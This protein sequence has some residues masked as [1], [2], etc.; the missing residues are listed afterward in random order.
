MLKILKIFFTTLTILTM[1]VLYFGCSGQNTKG[2]TDMVINESAK[3]N[4]ISA[5]VAKFGDSAR[6]RIDKGVNQVSLRW[7]KSDGTAQDFQ[8]FCLN[9][10]S[11]DSV[12]L[13]VIF[14][15]FQDHLESL[16]GNLL[17]I[18]RNFNWQLQ[19]DVGPVYAIDYLFAN[20]EPY[21]HVS[22]D[23]F[24]TKIAFAAL[25]NFPLETLEQKNLEGLNWPRK[26][27]AEVRLVED[28]SSR[29]P[30][31]VLQ[32]RSE[33]YTLADDYISNYNIYMHNLID[34][35]GQRLFPAD[36]K[37]IS[38]W[39]LR[40]EL[41]AQYANAG[42]FARQ[43]MI[44][45]VM[46]RI[47][48]QEIPEKVIDNEKFDW[49]PYDNKVYQ[50]GTDSVVA[51]SAEPNTRYNHIWDIYQGEKLVDPYYPQAPSLID[52]RF[53][54]N[55]EMSKSDVENLLKS[56]LQAPILKDIAALIQKRLGRPLEPFDIWYTGFKPKSSYNE[57]ALD[58][59]VGKMYPH[60]AAFQ[61]D[62]PY[63]LRKIGFSPQKSEFLAEHIQVD[64]SRGAGHAMGA[65]MRTDKAHLRTR[66]P[67]GGM[68]YKGFN[69]AIHELGHN[70]EQIFSLN[71]VDYYTLNGVPNTAFTE[72]F[73]FVFQ[74]RDLKVL[75]L[76]ESS[77]DAEYLRALNDIWATMEISGVA[78]T[79]IYIWEWMYE[80]PQA[81]PEELKQAMITISK[82]VWN[83]YFTP[84]LGMPDQILLAIYSH[85]VDGGMYTPD[86]PL[87]HIISFQIEQYLQD[88]A[89]ATE[90]E[91]MCRLGRLSPQIWMQQAV[92]S[93]VSSEPLIKAA[94]TA[95][96][97]IKE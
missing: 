34:N 59:I 84:V 12:Q 41:K 74:S 52:R 47:I 83:D 61:K 77:S 64:P 48:L 46:Q 86:Y 71:E 79:D 18:S 69:I 15:R 21:A 25:L 95:S 38:H 42:G 78:L 22:E 89:L 8:D 14:T 66:I 6:D 1:S 55:R 30:A 17:R 28:F 63:I 70:V 20:Y 29:V 97:K 45:E 2:Q 85:I 23:L 62:L 36:L 80:H 75:G 67:T 5:M 10:F 35:E 39:G 72:A 40:D 56:V 33:A 50:A 96:K 43:K 65:A 91:R 16:Y 13:N 11:T 60:V 19:V 3:E 93:K 73:A 81:N 68:K 4:T 57:E 87:G 24:K 51:A 9:N 44:Q 90:M 26:K 54:I 31:D 27:W 76:S 37:L 82:Q 7:H 88:H 53:K 32:K 58:K 92:G 49:N 94:E